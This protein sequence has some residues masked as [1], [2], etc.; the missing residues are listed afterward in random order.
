MRIRY[1][2][3]AVASTLALG[4]GAVAPGAAAQASARW[5]AVTQAKAPPAAPV[6]MPAT[7]AYISAASVRSVCSSPPNSGEEFDRC[8][9]ATWAGTSCQQNLN[10]NGAHG[11]FNVLA[12][13]NGC[14]VRVWLH[15][16]AWNGHNWGSG[17]SYCI[18]GGAFDIA[19][20]SS[21]QH[22]LNIY[23]SSNSSS[24]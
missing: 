8:T 19:I 16:D 24:C 14:F 11:P 20:P 15:Q 18:P 13:H 21:F 12:A 1:V 2:L 9:G 7:T 6:A 23:V 5:H 3:L 10:Y 22:P 4:V 17:W